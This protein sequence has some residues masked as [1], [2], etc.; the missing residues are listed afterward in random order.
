MPRVEE[1]SPG[2]LVAP[3]ASAAPA[4][5]PSPRPAPR[6]PQT[7]GPRSSSSLDSFRELLARPQR[8]RRRSAVA[9]GAI[10]AEMVPLAPWA[11]AEGAPRAPSAP[12]IRGTSDRTIEAPTLPGGPRDR[13]LLGVG[14]HRAE[15]RLFFGQGPLAG[16][17]IYLQHGPGGVHAVVL[18][19]LESSRK[20]LSVAMHEVARRLA[21]KGH[22]FRAAGCLPADPE[23]LLV[24][25]DR[26]GR[27]DPG[28]DGG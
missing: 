3:P 16:A 6:S 28:R 26:A 7:A 27:R 17:E 20:T 24:A 14:A 22:R 19:R 2:A 15:A 13:L 11:R 4:A 18:T 8:A 1:R 25:V 10:D 9:D 21:R 5:A 12:A 23:G